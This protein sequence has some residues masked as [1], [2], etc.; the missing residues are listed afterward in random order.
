MFSTLEFLTLLGRDNGKILE[1]ATIPKLILN[2]VII[3]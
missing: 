1:L 2:R 3:N